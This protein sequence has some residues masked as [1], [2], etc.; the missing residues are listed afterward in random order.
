MPTSIREQVV[1]A[2]ANRISAG[3]TIQLDGNAD[4]PARAVW[5]FSESADRTSY[6]ALS[7]TLGLSVGYMAE[8]DRAKGASQQ[9]NEMLAALLEDALNNDPTLGGLAQSINYSDSTIDYPEPGQNEIAILAS[10]EIVYETSATS[11]YQ[12]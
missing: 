1:Q 8:F 6:G 7:L 9:A 10:F 5:D 4:L 12:S 3:R 2:F 11:P